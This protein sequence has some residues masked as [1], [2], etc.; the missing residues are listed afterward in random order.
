MV[1][2]IIGAVLNIALDP[3]FIFVFDMGVRG[4]AVATVISQAC[5]CAFVTAFLCSK[6]SGIRIRPRLF[7]LN[8]RL[9]GR[10]LA[11]GVSPFVMQATESAVQIVF[12]IQL[13]AY[14]DGSKV[15]SA[16]MTIMMSVLQMVTLPLNGLGTGV[17][18]LISFNFGAGKFDRIKKAVKYLFC[19]TFTLCGLMWLLCLLWPGLFAAVFSATEEV[20]A[21]VTAYMPFFMGGCIFFSAQSAFQNT[22]LALGQA[23]ISIFLALLRKVIL[24]I[25]LTFVL[26]LFLGV[27]GIFLAESVSDTLAGLFTALTFALSIRRILKKRADLLAQG[28]NDLAPEEAKWP[29]KKFFEKTLQNA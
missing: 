3:L 16:A 4:A 14:T 5:S 21:V 28:G 10:T 8:L 23:R 17:Q 20:T 11:L 19:C 22:F 1:T 27:Q 7:G 2:V 9:V 24:L 13:Y 15:Y 25:P 6:R 29:R 26:P 12:N 18:P